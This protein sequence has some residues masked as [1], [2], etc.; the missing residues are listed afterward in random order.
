MAIH[1]ISLEKYLKMGWITVWKYLSLSIHS[2][3]RE[4][5]QPV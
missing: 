3:E 5:K 2:L 1:P 4:A